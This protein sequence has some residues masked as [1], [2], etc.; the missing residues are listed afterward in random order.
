MTFKG[1]FRA[2]RQG[3]ML[4]LALLLA[5]GLSGCK[6]KETI[7]T[8]DDVK[9]IVAHYGIP[10]TPINED[11]NRDSV[12]ARAYNEVKPSRY[13]VDTEQTLSIYVYASSSDAIKG[14][15]DF[16]EK[17]AAADVI[18]H[19]RY[20][21]NNLVLY[22][23]SRNKQKQDRV[24]KAMHD[25]RVFAEEPNKA[26]DLSEK[27]KADYR[28]KAWAMLD[29]AQRG[30]T[31]IKPEDA[32]VTTMVLLRGDHWLVPNSDR[33]E[34]RYHRLVTVTF[35]TTNDGLLGP[36][37]IVMNPV[38]DQLVGFFPRF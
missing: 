7:V 33:S 20:Q 37:V 19:T 14:V 30:E 35:K 18:A 28:E 12:F 34:L 11:E 24:A 31:S 6:E 1:H 36:I 8:L 3:V 29:E 27:G 25:V 38:D 2:A 15:K 22:S 32:E 9:S 23:I 16:E 4:I 5:F 26:V 13:V 17:T 10:T 21:I